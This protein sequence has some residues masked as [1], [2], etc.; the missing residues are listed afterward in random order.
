MECSATVSKL[1]LDTP[2]DQ[3][4]REQMPTRIG[5]LHALLE[6]MAPVE[7][8]FAEIWPD[9]ELIHLY[10]GSLYVDYN[11]CG[12]ITPDIT[13]RVSELVCYSAASGAAGILFTG[14]L[15]GEPVKAARAGLSIPVLTAYEA[16]IEAAFA[17]GTRFGSTSHC[18]RH[19]L[20]G[21]RRHRVLRGVESN[22]VYI[23]LSHRRGCDGCAPSG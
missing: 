23:G 12:Q 20:A 9:V 22:L 11:R 2:L 1:N 19:D 18:G 15:F 6:S 10:D 13:R 4:R 21:A 8:A 16:M 3:R 17:E 14:S 5:L 7:K